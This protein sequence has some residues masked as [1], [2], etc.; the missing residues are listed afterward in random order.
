M[1]T[2]LQ[3]ALL[4]GAFLG[5]GAVLLIARLMPA[6]PDLAD[7]APGQLFLCRQPR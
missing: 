5:L 3:V 1:T 2:G 4:G 7:R 6:E